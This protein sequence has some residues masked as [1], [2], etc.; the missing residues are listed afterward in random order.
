MTAPLQPTNLVLARV[1]TRTVMAGGQA[2]VNNL[3]YVVSSVGSPIATDTD[4]ATTV[5]TLLFAQ[6]KGLMTSLGEYRGV[7]AQIFDGQNKPYRALYSPAFTNA[8]A[9]FG[10]AGTSP[11]PPQTAGLISFQTNKPRQANRGRTYIPWPDSSAES[12]G[13]SPDPVYLSELGVLATNMSVGLAVSVAGRT[14]T[15][16]RVI[17]HGKSRPGN[18]VGD[19]PTPVI[20]P[21]LS[22]SVSSGWATQ[23]RRGAFGRLNKSPI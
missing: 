16:V 20:D 19:Y 8:N 12:G 4:V 3:W 22:V 5:D 11:L 21:V 17:K 2:A 9:G 13:G 10:T 1:W 23:R 14:A 18:V 15:L 7:Q 6:Y